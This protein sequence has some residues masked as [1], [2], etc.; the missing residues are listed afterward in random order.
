MS[1]LPEW[2]DAIRKDATLWREGAKY[3]VLYC[4]TDSA[5]KWALEPAAEYFDNEVL[6]DLWFYDQYTRTLQDETTFKAQ[7]HKWLDGPV[8]SH[9]VTYP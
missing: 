3:R 2:H 4:S 5:G 7:I 8:Y 1:A 6:L 9:S